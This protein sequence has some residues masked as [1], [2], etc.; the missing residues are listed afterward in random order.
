MHR[1]LCIKGNAA[2][3]RT[4]EQCTE[5]YTGWVMQ[6]GRA[7][8][9]SAQRAIRNGFLLTTFKIF[10]LFKNKNR[11]KKLLMAGFLI[12]VAHRSSRHVLETSLL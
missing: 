6:L 9:N 5:S 1:E 3:E 12:E 11:Q 8:W 7:L 4:V 10:K 2:K